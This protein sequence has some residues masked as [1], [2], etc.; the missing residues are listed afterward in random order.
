MFTYF[1][2]GK[3]LPE[4]A[5][6]DLNLNKTFKALDIELEGEV[7]ISIILNQVLVTV[8]VIK[9]EN[10]FLLKRIVNSLLDAEMSKLAFI[11][12][13]SYSAIID[14]CL[15]EDGAEDWVYGIDYPLEK[16]VHTV[17]A[18][19]EMLNWMQPLSVGVEGILIERCLND[20][21]SA[22]THLDDAPF[23]CYRAIETLRNHCA[24][25]NGI[26][27]SSESRAAQWQTIRDAIGITKEEIGYF[28]QW[29]T[30]LRHGHMAYMSGEDESNV[31]NKTHSIL[32]SYFKYLREK[33][34][35]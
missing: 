10:I 24:D 23:Y 34:G 32:H 30:Q 1:F 4:R 3:V 33:K 8:K 7:I 13:F 12:G 35:H 20:F 21:K 19:N 26:S 29:A 27:K 14:R 15:K 9:E 6:L 16:G 28:T 2:W 31:L 17:G 25:I 5:R 18:I 11:R 22:L